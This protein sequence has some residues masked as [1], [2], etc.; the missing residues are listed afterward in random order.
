MDRVDDIILRYKNNEQAHPNFCAHLKDEPVSHAKAKI[1]KTR[2]FT[3]APFDWTIVV[4]KYM[5]SFTRLVQNERLAFESAPGTIAQSI[6]WQEMYI[7]LQ[8]M[9]WRI[10]LQVIIK[11][12][13]RK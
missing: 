7:T 11:P 5:L 13:T 10:L 4:R 1:G 6:E 2:V 12:L 8:N 9:V 3:G